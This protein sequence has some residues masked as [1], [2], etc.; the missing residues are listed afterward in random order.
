MLSAIEPYAFIFSADSQILCSGGIDRTIKLR[1]VATGRCNR[2]LMG[3]RNSLVS[4]AAT[5][6]LCCRIISSVLHLLEC[7]PVPEY[8][9]P[10]HPL[11]QS[12]HNEDQA[13]Y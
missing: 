13:W 12:R 9:V 7:L 10:L 1:D 8:H 4:S 11:K 6:L 3:E 5:R 2:T